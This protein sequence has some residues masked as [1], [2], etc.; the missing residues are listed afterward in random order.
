[1]GNRDIVPLWKRGMKGD[2]MIMI[3]K[4]PLTPLFQ[5]G[6]PNEKPEEPKMKRSAG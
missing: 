4:S 3:Y 6:E 2:F 1:V 5:R